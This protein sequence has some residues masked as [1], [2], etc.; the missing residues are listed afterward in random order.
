MRLEAAVPGET[1]LCGH[2]QRRIHLIWKEEIALARLATPLQPLAPRLAFEGS[3]ALTPR[4]VHGCVGCPVVGEQVLARGQSGCASTAAHLVVH[5]VLLL[6]LVVLAAV[7]VVVVVVEL[8]ILPCARVVRLVLL[9]LGRP[10]RIRKLL[11]RGPRLL[12]QWLMREAI[13]G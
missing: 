1:R 7:V 8:P 11:I 2:V 4:G 5:R 12:N 9:V 10:L 6:V 3:L 13:S